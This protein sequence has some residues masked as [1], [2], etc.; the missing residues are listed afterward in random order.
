MWECGGETVR[1]RGVGVWR[2]DVGGRGVGVWRGDSGREL[3]RSVEG[4]GAVI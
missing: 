1:R 2:G 3:C 4:Q